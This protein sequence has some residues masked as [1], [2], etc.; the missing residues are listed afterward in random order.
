MS[1][2]IVQ[3]LTNSVYYSILVIEIWLS[4]V[5]WDNL[6]IF[7]RQERDICPM[8]NLGKLY[9]IASLGEL[10]PIGQICPMLYWTDL[11]NGVLDRSVHWLMAQYVHTKLITQKFCFS[12]YFSLP[13]SP[14]LPLSYSSS[15]SPPSIRLWQITDYIHYLTMLLYLIDYFC[16]PL[17]WVRFEP[18]TLECEGTTL[19][20]RPPRLSHHT[21][22]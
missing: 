3:K 4:C 9:F 10:W 7:S 16:L 5:S 15:L 19:V 6:R 21:Y 17:C 1:W 11:S 2:I 13:P 18:M 14:S 12:S 22:N 20:T 8:R